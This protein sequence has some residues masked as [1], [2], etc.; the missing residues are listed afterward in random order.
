MPTYKAYYVKNGADPFSLR[1]KKDDVVSIT[2]AK[3]SGKMLL[4]E[5]ENFAKKNTPKGY[6]FSRVEKL[7]SVKKIRRN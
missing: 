2:S 1:P 3:V 5:V 6:Q 7:T 4:P